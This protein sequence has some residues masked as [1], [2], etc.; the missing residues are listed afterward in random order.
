MAAHSTCQPGRPRPSTATP[1]PAPRAARPARAGSRAGASCRAGPGRRRARRTARASRPRRDRRPSPNA[2]SECT[3]KYR[4]PV[5]V[6]DR[7][8][9]RQPL[10]HRTIERDRLDGA[11]EGVGGQHPQRGHV[12]AEQLGLALGE[13]GPVHPGG[14]GA[15][16]QRVVDVGDVLDVVH[17]VPGVAPGAVEQVEGDVGGGVAEVGGVVGRDAADVE[18]RRLGRVGGHD[19][20]ATRC[21]EGAP[22]GPAGGRA[23]ARR[24]SSKHAWPHASGPPA[25]PDSSA[26]LR[27]ATTGRSLTNPSW[28]GLRRP[29]RGSRA[30]RRTGPASGCAAAA[31]RPRRAAVGDLLGRAAGRRAGRAG[32]CPG[33]R[34][35]RSTV[36]TETGSS[37]CSGS[38]AQ[39]HSTVRSLCSRWKERPWST[40]NR[41]PSGMARMWPPLRSALLTST[42]KTA[43]RRSAALSSWTSETGRSRPS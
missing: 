37:S 22:A 20:A 36:R 19:R 26:V 28:A 13:L 38:R 18:P 10:H 9:L 7:A 8:A 3:E 1:R 21:H 29:A 42:S 17:L 2:G 34:A 23:G 39:P 15:L 25:H 12:L 4:S 27:G 24:G 5:D 33:R 14:G 16:Q 41:C 32:R 35:G 11:D 40:P 43:I 6:V 31:S 30:A